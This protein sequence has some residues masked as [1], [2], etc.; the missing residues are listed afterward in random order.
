MYKTYFELANDEKTWQIKIFNNE[1]K[2]R[3]WINK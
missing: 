3:E 1:N 2:A